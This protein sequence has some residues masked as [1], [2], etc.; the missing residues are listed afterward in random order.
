MADGEWC[1][2]KCL[3]SLPVN[4]RGIA[5]WIIAVGC[6]SYYRA[7]VL[8]T[9]RVSPVESRL[10]RMDQETQH[11]V[12]RPLRHWKSPRLRRI[13]SEATIAPL[14]DHTHYHGYAQRHGGS[15][16]PYLGMAPL[17]IVQRSDHTSNDTR[18][19][20]W[21]FFAKFMLRLLAHSCTQQSSVSI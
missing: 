4:I 1:R 16:V 8:K 15:L 11:N 18:G 10:L 3:K 9:A 6:D 19:R 21:L 7:E 14:Y 12:V 20:G 13:G 2:M 5:P 17:P